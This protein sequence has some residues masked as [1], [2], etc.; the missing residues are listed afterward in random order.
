MPFT[1]VGNIKNPLRAVCVSGQRFL[2]SRY[3]LIQYS[4]VDHRKGKEIRGK[5]FYT[6][7]SSNMNRNTE[8]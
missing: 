8:K 1:N 3:N 4:K 5:I 6:V 2:Y 7:P